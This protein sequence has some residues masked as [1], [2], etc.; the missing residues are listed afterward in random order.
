[1]S[2]VAYQDL[3][4]GPI[5]INSKFGKTLRNQTME[6]GKPVTEVYRGWEK[7]YEKGK[8]KQ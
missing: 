5:D 7:D 4:D 3:P 8:Q 1:M 6:A 2:P